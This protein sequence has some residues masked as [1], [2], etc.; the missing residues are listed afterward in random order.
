MLETRGCHE[1]VYLKDTAVTSAELP[2]LW[3]IDSKRVFLI[4]IRVPLPEFLIIRIESMGEDRDDNFDH[5][6]DPPV[7]EIIPARFAL[8]SHTDVVAAASEVAV[9]LRQ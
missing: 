9:F 2:T 8:R 1:L 5:E 7:D 4:I 3:S 6:W